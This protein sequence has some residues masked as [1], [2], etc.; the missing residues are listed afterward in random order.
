M[1]K[2]LTMFRRPTDVFRS[3][4]LDAALL[5]GLIIALLQTAGC[6]PVD[7]AGN[8]G[9]SEKIEPLEVV[10][11]ESGVQQ[12]VVPAGSFEIGSGVGDEGPRQT[13][14]LSSFAMDQ[15]EVLQEELTRLQVPDASHFKDPRRPVEM[16][17]WSEA[18]M[19]C[20]ERSKAEGLQ[21]CYDE[22]TFE[23]DFSADGYRLPT[24]ADGSHVRTSR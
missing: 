14:S 22:L 1:P 13:I 6:K 2:L 8:G 4:L 17:R 10:T 19:L 24:E 16:V 21:P 3:A 5:T 15:Y 18:A 12:L 20:N 7:S 11:T 23:C 9:S